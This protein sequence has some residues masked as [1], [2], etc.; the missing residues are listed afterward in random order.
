M[1]DKSGS[2]GVAASPG[3]AAYSSAN[4][5]ELEWADNVWKG[6]RGKSGRAL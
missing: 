1:L 5:D 6:L 3:A 2:G 4:K